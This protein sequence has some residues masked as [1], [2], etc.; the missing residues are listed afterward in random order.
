[1]IAFRR[2]VLPERPI[3]RAMLSSVVVLGLG[4]AVYA[5]WQHAWGRQHLQA[6]TEALVRR[7]FA[8]GREHLLL[9]LTVWPRDPTIQARLAQAARRA[10][11]RETAAYHRELGQRLGGACAELDLETVLARVQ[12]GDLAGADAT[13][14]QRFEEGDPQSVLILEAL[15]QGYLKTFHLHGA[16]Y[17]AER[18]LA[19]QPDHVPALLWHAQ[20][21]ERLTR[22]PE[23]V[24]DYERAIELEPANELA[25][26][27][28]G[29]LSLHL[30][31]PETA[32]EQFEVL[33]RT[34]PEN[35]GVQ[36]G[37]ASCLRRMGQ[38]GEAQAILDRLVRDFPA[39]PLITSERGRLALEAGETKLA[40][41]WLRKAAA[42]LPYD[43]PTNYALYQ[44]L[45]RNGQTSEARQLQSRLQQ[46]E[47]DMTRLMELSQRIL[48]HPRSAADRCEAG[49]L[50]LRLGLVEA[51]LHWLAGALQEDPSF[52]A[53]HDALANYHEKAGHMAE[54]QRHRQLAAQGRLAAG[55]ARAR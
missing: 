4:L 42:Q 53:A 39:E 8:T 55:S 7:D 2:M 41:P 37:R 44:C 45:E 35:P 25:R 24:A 49:V 27:S 11:D 26:L 33:H 38:R 36:L 10:G 28:L 13:L 16:A 30:N 21:M 22:F 1:M 34:Q 23:A 47:K 46:L 43:L 19:L 48:K 40:E 18:L 31:K 9:A 12:D 50:C 29:E 6:G 32:L 52:P 5:G 14:R 51:G 20:V 54:A 3:V 17:C 15:T